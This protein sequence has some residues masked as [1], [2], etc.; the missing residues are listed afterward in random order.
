GPSKN[1]PETAG[2]MERAAPSFEHRL[3][4]LRYIPLRSRSERDELRCK[5][6]GCERLK[7]GYREHRTV[8]DQLEHERLFVCED[9][10]HG[11]AD[12]CQKKAASKHAIPETARI[13]GMLGRGRLRERCPDFVECRSRFAVTP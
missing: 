12:A 13:L 8:C 6:W 2:S 3:A 5:E 1:R 9:E 4:E 11:C 10:T 7:F